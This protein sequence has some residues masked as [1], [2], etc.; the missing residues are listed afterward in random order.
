MRK[1]MLV[2]MTNPV[3]GRVD[4]YDDWYTNEHLTDVVGLEGYDA[5][6]RFRFT[7]AHPAGAEPPTYR[8]MALYE[9]AEENL[10]AAKASL[11]AATVERAEAE[12]AGRKPQVPVSQA[13]NPDR[14]AYW[15][16][17]HSDRVVAPPVT[18]S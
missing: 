6:Q 8:Y 9:V 12:V 15:F 13:M 11:A 2:V 16:V 3:E 4:E 17:E 14:V 1:Y 7:D 5:A 10:E 18:G